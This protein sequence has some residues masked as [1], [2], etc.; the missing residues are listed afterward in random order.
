[1]KRGV[2]RKRCSASQAALLGPENNCF[3]RTPA[4]GTDPCFS[5]MKFSSFSAL[6]TLTKREP[7]KAPSNATTAVARARHRAD[8]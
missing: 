8:C 7:N 4:A 2:W 3:P 6:A 5:G 1:M